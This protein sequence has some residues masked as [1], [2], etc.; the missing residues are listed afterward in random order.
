MIDDT[1]SSVGTSFS[2]DA[3][4]ICVFANDCVRSPLPSLVT[5]TDE[6]VSAIKKL[7]PVIPTSDA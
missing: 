5:I 7:A 4:T 1:S 6:P 3:M 2:I